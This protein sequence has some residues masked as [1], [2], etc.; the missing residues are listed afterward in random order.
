MI[1]FINSGNMATAILDAMPHPV[2][3]VDYDI[4]ILSINKASQKM[5][6]QKPEVIIK[7]SAGEILNC[8]HSEE[9][10]GCG[11]SIFCSECKFRNSV[12]NA[13]KKGITTKEKTV[14]DL[15]TKNGVEKVNFAF[16]A[17]PF[18]HNNQK[19][20][21]LQIEN[22]TEI[23]NDSKII[24]ICC[25]CAMIKNEEEQWNKPEV[26]LNKKLGLRFSHSICPDCFTANYGEYE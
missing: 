13:F 26:H 8:I 6:G 15:T 14:L 10:E 21:Y 19:Y 7:R 17:S 18:E 25:Y 22:I 4:T 5:I 1:P 3:L 9:T 24:P 23:M 11:R 2:F 16:I 20:V 12:N